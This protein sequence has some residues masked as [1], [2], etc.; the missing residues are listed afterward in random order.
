MID[1]RREQHS[2]VV[3]GSGAQHVYRNVSLMWSVLQTEE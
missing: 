1:T 2:I 3:D